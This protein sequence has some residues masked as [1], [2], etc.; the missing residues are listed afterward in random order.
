MLNMNEYNSW[1][2]IRTKP[3]LPNV[4]EFVASL[5]ET[6]DIN[7]FL[8]HVRSAFKTHFCESELFICLTNNSNTNVN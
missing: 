7:T 6:N 8:R 3:Q 1:I 5:N 2:V 4:E